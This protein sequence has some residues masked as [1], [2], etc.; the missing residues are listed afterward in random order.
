M[1]RRKDSKAG[2]VLPYVLQAYATGELEIHG[3]AP[4]TLISADKGAAVIEFDGKRHYVAVGEHFT[5]SPLT[6]RLYA[7]DA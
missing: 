7:P 3:L 2:P 1:R 4:I 5:L 6:V